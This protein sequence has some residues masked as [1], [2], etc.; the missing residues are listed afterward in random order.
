MAISRVKTNENIHFNY[1]PDVKYVQTSLNVIKFYNSLA[2]N[3]ELKVDDT[4]EQKSAYQNDM[5]SILS[6]FEKL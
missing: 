1:A 2:F 5:N 4:V 6:A 3:A